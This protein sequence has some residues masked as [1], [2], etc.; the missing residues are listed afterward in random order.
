MSKKKIV[1][2]IVI[3]LLMIWVG[4][5]YIFKPIL[6]NYCYQYTFGECPSVCK[7]QCVSSNCG[8]DMRSACTADCNGKGSCSEPSWLD[9][10]YVFREIRQVFEYLFYKR[11]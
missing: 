1:V 6:K 2:L 3:I 8:K 9:E 10:P 7:E 11:F 5:L 4:V